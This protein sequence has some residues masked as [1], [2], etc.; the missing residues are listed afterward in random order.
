MKLFS[1]IDPVQQAHISRWFYLLPSDKI[2]KGGLTIYVRESFGLCHWTF[3]LCSYHDEFSFR[4]GEKVVEERIE[5]GLLQL[6]GFQDAT[7]T[8]FALFYVSFF[9]DHLKKI[10]VYKHTINRAI[11]G[12]RQIGIV[13]L[14]G[15]Q[16]SKMVLRLL[17]DTIS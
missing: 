1:Q 17:V 2:Q 13:N 7:D 10:P 15:K 16:L 12:F 3:S 14:P 9:Y 8:L 6:G 4:E 5:R 11:N